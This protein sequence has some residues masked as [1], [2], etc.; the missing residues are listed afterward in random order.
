MR[1]ERPR[2]QILGVNE[3]VSL[4]VC[5]DCGGLTAAETWEK[6]VKWHSGEEKQAEKDRR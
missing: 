5:M 4:L 2:Y 3:E 1:D 6:H